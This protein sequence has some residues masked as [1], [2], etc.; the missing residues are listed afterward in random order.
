MPMW[1]AD[2]VIAGW[3]HARESRRGRRLELLF[4]TFERVL[5]AHANVATDRTLKF[6]PLAARHG[7]VWQGNPQPL[8]RRYEG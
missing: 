3:N 5:D 8:H 7:F 4:A 2:T 6:L 1:V